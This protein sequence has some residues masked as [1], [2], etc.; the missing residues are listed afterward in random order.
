MTD[1]STQPALELCPF[2]GGEARLYSVSMPMAE[3]VA[4]IHVCCIECDVVGP[5]IMFDQTLDS[6]SDIPDR[7]AEAVSAWNTRPASDREARLEAELKAANKRAEYWER[8][9]ARAH[10]ARPGE[11]SAA[12]GDGS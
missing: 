10:G 6:E 5:S 4:D 3:D 7:E 11:Q 9:W 8:Q 12:L 1:L 2:C